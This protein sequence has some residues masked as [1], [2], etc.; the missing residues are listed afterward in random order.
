M[1]LKPLQSCGFVQMPECEGNMHS[2][3]GMRMLFGS[4][5]FPDIRMRNGFLTVG[6]NNYVFLA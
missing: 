2:P 1:N 5:I 4:Q 3:V 6:H